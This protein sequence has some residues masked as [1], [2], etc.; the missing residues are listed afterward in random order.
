MKYF[1]KVLVILVVSIAWSSCD[2][3]FP[4]P[5]ASVVPKFTFSIDNE[6]V[7]P[8]NVTFTNNSI[9]PTAAGVVT[10]TWN[11]GD[12]TSSN[13]VNPVH[14]YQEAGIYEVK[15]VIISSGYGTIKEVSQK[16]VI[17]DP[18]AS[19]IPIYFTNGTLVY[20]GLINDAIPVFEQI[21]VTNIQGS[22][23]LCI[24]TIHN[25]LYIADVDAGQIIQA[26]LDG[27]NQKVWRSGLDSPNGM[28]IDYQNNKM[29][30]DNAAGIQRTDLN[31][32]QAD[33]Y[34]DFVT[35]Q[36]N[37]PEDVA[38]DAVNRNLYWINYDGG[39]WVKGLDGGG[40]KEIIPDAEGGS[41]IVVG[42]KIYFDFYNGSGD[43]QLKS[44]DLD[45]SNIAT[46][47]T[48]ISR[49]M[50]GLGYEPSTDKIY[51]GDRNTGTIKRCNTDGSGNEVFYSAAGSSPRGIVFGK[52]KE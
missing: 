30:W 6:G 12:N 31:S 39:V 14:L 26:D 49:V 19:G 35:G 24:D 5:Q 2:K 38:I 4:V 7:A 45:G 17:K 16:V 22:Y 36:A 13:E 11:F 3:D 46:L 8:A 23:G 33:L 48:G 37:D 29:Y 32:D 43:I 40:E 10:Y 9:I 50:Y 41:I 52:K 44:A 1:L 25:K 47:A 21:P 18:N 51:Y 28:A 20:S 34:E 42:N 27:K 15:L